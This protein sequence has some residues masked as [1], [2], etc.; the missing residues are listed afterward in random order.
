VIEVGKPVQAKG[1]GEL[2]T[3]EKRLALDGQLI[4]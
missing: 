4:V 2:V 1:R 3:E